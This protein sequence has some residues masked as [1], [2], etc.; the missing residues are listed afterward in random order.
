M[1]K[2]GAGRGQLPGEARLREETEAYFNRC[3][4]EGVPPTP[5]GLAL[6]LGVRTS[7]LRG[8]NLTLGQRRVIDRAMQRIEAGTMELLLTKGGVKGMESVL[9][10]VQ[11]EA[12]RGSGLEEMGDEELMERLNRLLPRLLEM[13]K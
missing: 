11:E 6:A 1:G 13:K 7:A 8:D 10:R 4:G 3:A 2:G 9:E 12:G 5:S